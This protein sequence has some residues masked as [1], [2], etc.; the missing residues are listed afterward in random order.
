MGDPSRFFFPCVRLCVRA[1]F[2]SMLTYYRAYSFCPRSNR[3][4]VTTFYIFTFLSNLMASRFAQ[5]RPVKITVFA[6]VFLLPVELKVWYLGN[7]NSG[8]FV[9]LWHPARN[10]GLF[11]TFIRCQKCPFCARSL[12]W[13]LAHFF[14]FNDKPF[15]WT[16][17]MRQRNS[18]VPPTLVL[19]KTPTLPLKTKNRWDTPRVNK[20]DTAICVRREKSYFYKYSRLI[21]PIY[22]Y[23]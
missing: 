3:A 13:F 10:E 18:H 8:N 19:T 16:S 4:K 11:G 17:L 2:R 21:G 12:W 6:L 5:P 7:L 20:A 14:F 15:T 22:F 9:V 1:E 23:L